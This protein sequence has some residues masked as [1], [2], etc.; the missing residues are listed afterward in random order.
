MARRATT[1]ILDSHPS[2][3]RAWGRA[4][5]GDTGDGGARTGRDDGG[6]DTWA[7][8]VRSHAVMGSWANLC[9]TLMTA[10]L[11]TTLCGPDTM[12]YAEP[13]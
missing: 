3:R 4:R 9:Y 7:V 12:A 10:M 5:V 6:K 2:G 8:V 13:R 11:D 1:D